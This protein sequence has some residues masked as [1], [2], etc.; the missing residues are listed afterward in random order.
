MTT[1]KRRGKRKSEK[2]DDMTSM[3]FGEHEELIVPFLMEF[4]D[5]STL[6]LFGSTNRKNQVHLSEEV[7]RRKSRF[8]A[9]QHKISNELLS[10][11]NLMPSRE[12]VYQALNLRQ[13]VC[14][15]IDSGLGRVDH[16]PI[17]FT[18]VCRL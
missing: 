8:K 4:L 11:G 14:R 12:K 17:D 10:A 5:V 16:K 1:E 7:A 9:I 3:P 15:L 13:E 2:S 18:N 6:V